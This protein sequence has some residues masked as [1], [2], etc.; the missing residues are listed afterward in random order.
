MA[1]SVHP[2]TATKLC[3]PMD[4]RR[5]VAGTPLGGSSFAPE[6]RDQSLQQ[7]RPLIAID[8]E[9]R[10]P[11]EFELPEFA[12]T[13]NPGDPI[14]ADTLTIGTSS[15]PF[16]SFLGLYDNQRYIP[17]DTMGA[18][19]VSHYVI[20]A[21]GTFRVLSRGNP[22]RLLM[23]KPMDEFF[24]VDR[25]F[26]PTV[27]FDTGIGRWIA[28]CVNYVQSPVRSTNTIIAVSASPD[29]TRNWYFY[30]IPTPGSDFWADFPRL[31]FSSALIAVTVNY[32]TTTGAWRNVG[33]YI[34]S[35]TMAARGATLT[36][37]QAQFP[38]PYAA[39]CPSMAIDND[40]NRVWLMQT[41][42]T[43]APSRLLSIQVTA[44][45][46]ESSPPTFQYLPA[47]TVPGWTAYSGGQIHQQAP[48]T[49]LDTLI[50]PRN[51]DA[52]DSR[53]GNVIYRNGYLWTTHNIFQV[54]TSGLRG[55]VQAEMFVPGATA[56]VRSARIYN[57]TGTTYGFPSIAVTRGAP[58]EALLGFTAFPPGA[59]PSAAYSNWPSNDGPL[60]P[61]IYK[62]GEGIYN[63]DFNY[64]NV[65]F[66]DYSFTCS[67]P[68]SRSFWTIQEATAP[69]SAVNLGNWQLWVAQVLPTV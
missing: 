4:C 52:G 60:Q 2:P 1:S 38:S 35:K 6:I 34:I 39:L 21:N 44:G 51:L 16:R 28:S 57:S 58:G 41:E 5:A 47:V 33:L 17:P 37:W 20:I 61:T 32:F 62:D 18:V 46:T 31:G 43:S 65:R 54:E 22:P 30:R 10:M 66:G 27:I 56:V 13:G 64:G 68:L 9:R 25:T 19:G 23:N 53:M 8:M 55:G 12:P 7:I 59:W 14:T 45:P 24:G 50:A 26:D 42:S 67:D 15:G 36:F 69:Y 11:Q 63:K 29:P 40:T 49:I 48:Q 3:N